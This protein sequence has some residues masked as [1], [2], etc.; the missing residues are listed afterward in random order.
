MELKKARIENVII[1]AIM[2]VQ[3]GI[4]KDQK[5]VH[6]LIVFVVILTKYILCI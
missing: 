5:E 1:V 6:L 2:M 3:G 4:A